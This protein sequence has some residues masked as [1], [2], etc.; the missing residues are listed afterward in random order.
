MGLSMKKV[1]DEMEFD[2]AGNIQIATFSR[3][4]K[5]ITNLTPDEIKT[6]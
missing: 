3:K 4:L 5:Q 1:L 2:N 6:V